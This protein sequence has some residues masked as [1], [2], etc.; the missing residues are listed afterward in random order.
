M[1]IAIHGVRLYAYTYTWSDALC[2]M[3]Y[4]EGS[5]MLITI[6]EV[7]LYADCYT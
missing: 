5:Y 4:K 2:S 7:K 6:H 1:L 3:L